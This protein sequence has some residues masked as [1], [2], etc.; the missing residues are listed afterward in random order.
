MDVSDV[1]GLDM[2]PTCSL[3][4]VLS[5]VIINLTRL[6]ANVLKIADQQ[7]CSQLKYIRYLAITVAISLILYRRYLAIS[8]HVY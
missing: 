5:K 1:N 8:R 7:Y 6:I 2:N 3:D 4:F